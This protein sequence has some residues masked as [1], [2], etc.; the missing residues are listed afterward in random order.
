VSGPHRFR[1]TIEAAR[2]GGAVALIPAEL[3]E[4]LGGLKLRARFDGMS[5]SR[6]R[7]LADPI[8][9]AVRPETRAARLENALAALRQLG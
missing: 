7:E 9:E 4:E 6:R 8:R 1:S 3:V 2:G 5:L